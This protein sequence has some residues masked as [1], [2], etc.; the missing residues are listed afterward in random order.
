V[1]GEQNIADTFSTRPNEDTRI[2]TEREEGPTKGKDISKEIEEMGS[3]WGGGE[4]EEEMAF[5][6]NRRGGKRK[7]KNSRVNTQEWKSRQKGKPREVK[8]NNREPEEEDRENHE[9][10]ENKPEKVSKATKKPVEATPPEKENVTPKVLAQREPI[11]FF[12]TAPAS[13][14]LYEL[15]DKFPGFVDPQ[16]RMSLFTSPLNNLP[17]LPLFPLRSLF[18]S[19]FPS[20]CSFPPELVRFCLAFPLFFPS[21]ACSLRSRLPPCCSPPKLIHL[22]LHR[23][24]CPEFSLPPLL[25]GLGVSEIL[26]RLS[27]TGGINVKPLSV[28]E[29]F[30]NLKHILP[31]R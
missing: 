15:M 30:S 4:A 9:T 3:G 17:R 10:A 31:V 23:Q 21:G 27:R 8:N 22:C 5:A 12:Y 18:T 2:S 13:E 19:V 16:S 24:L 28:D 20:P 1:T 14:L 26:E 7:G 25:C 29:I 6:K 11:V